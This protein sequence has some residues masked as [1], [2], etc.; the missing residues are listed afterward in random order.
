MNFMKKIYSVFILLTFISMTTLAQDLTPEIQ[1][2]SDK[3]NAMACAIE[4]PA[5]LLNGQEP[6]SCPQSGAKTVRPGQKRGGGAKW[7]STDGWFTRMLKQIGRDLFGPTVR[8]MSFVPEDCPN[9]IEKDLAYRQ[10]SDEECEIDL[11]YDLLATERHGYPLTKMHQCQE[12][13]CDKFGIDKV[14]KIIKLKSLKP[15][16]DPARFFGCTESILI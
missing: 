14:K 11:M 2:F 4:K 16:Q 10:G 13:V 7:Q 9:I 12:F 5:S 3:L 1:E 6:I 8:R 15:I